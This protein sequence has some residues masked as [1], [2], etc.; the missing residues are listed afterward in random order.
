MMANHGY[1][2]GLMVYD[3]LLWLMLIGDSESSV[4]MVYRK[5][6]SPAER[7]IAAESSTSEGRGRL[8]REPGT[9]RR[10]TDQLGH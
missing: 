9:L 10:S 7:H 5:G 2:Q 8:E 3:G 6:R 4:R 1:N